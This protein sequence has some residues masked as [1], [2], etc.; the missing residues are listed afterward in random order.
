MQKFKKSPV[1][2]VCY[3]LAALALV[4]C[5]Y[6][7]GNSYKTVAEY[8]AAYNMKPQ[9]G[10]ILTYM[11][12]GG[13]T[14]LTSAVTLFMAAHILDAVRKLDPKNYVSVPAA[15][16]AVQ[17]ADDDIS[18]EAAA[19]EESENAAAAEEM[20][21]YE[22]GVV[23]FD[24]SE[25]KDT[26]DTVF[27]DE[28]SHEFTE[29]VESSAPEADADM[30]VEGEK[31]EFSK[32][33]EDLAGDYSQNTQEAETAEVKAEETAEAETAEISEDSE[34][35]SEGNADT[36]NADKAETADSSAEAPKPKKRRRRKPA[37]KQSDK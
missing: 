31:A 34:S 17:A 1:T 8:Y 30:T 15:D 29:F 5:C 6:V 4:Y 27:E 32:L 19:D 25:S 14:P 36:G 21:E 13:L 2:I 20:P 22:D 12:Q 3:V 16:A 28:D 11:L 10:E 18:A 9:I 33:A 26:E 23:E 7:L 37:N 35:V 24:G